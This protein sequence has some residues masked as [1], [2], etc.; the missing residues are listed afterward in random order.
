MIVA[1]DTK[2]LVRWAQEE[3][4]NLD[5]ARLDAL[6]GEVSALKGR[7]ILPTPVLAE[8]F[9]RV[10]EATADWL[11]SLQ[12]KPSVIVAP[13][14]LRAAVECGLLDA[15]AHAK[16]DKRGGRSDP[17]QR[18]KVDRQIVAI[19]KT[20]G[21]ELLVTDDKG[22]GITARAAGIQVKQLSTLPLPPDAAQR[23]LDLAPRKR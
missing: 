14:D 21:A 12:K 19:A 20:N 4:E 23:K 11:T 17:Y 5:A 9:V 7:V 1:L 22:L 13:F 3:S 8:F 6:L 16:G 15:A 2:C 18:I 10:N